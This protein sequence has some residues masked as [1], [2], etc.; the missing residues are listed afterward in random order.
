[1]AAAPVFTVGAR[2]PRIWAARCLRMNGSSR[3]I[4]PFRH[5]STAN[6]LI[7]VWLEEVPALIPIA[8]AWLAAP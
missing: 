7:S 6:A 3:L 4:G 1:V 2:T 5:G 8:G